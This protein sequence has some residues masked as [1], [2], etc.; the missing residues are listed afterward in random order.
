MNDD[1]ET[2]PLLAEIICESDCTASDET[3]QVKEDLVV[4]LCHDDDYK[5]ADSDDGSCGS[6]GSGTIMC[7][8]YCDS[9]KLCDHNFEECEGL[10]YPYCQHCERGE[11]CTT[12]YGVPCC[13]SLVNP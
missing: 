12:C 3:L 2:T 10:S 5:E 6:D 13:C 7:A 4:Y 1:C 11:R 9:C 8:G